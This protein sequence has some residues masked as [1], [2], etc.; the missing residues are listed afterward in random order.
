MRTICAVLF[1]SGCSTVTSATQIAANTWQIEAHHGTD[2]ATSKGLVMQAL[3]TCPFGYDLLQQMF[4]GSSFVV[5]CKP[6][7]AS[8]R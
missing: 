8:G 2:M 5:Q 4:D 3:K 7:V 1:L 6:E